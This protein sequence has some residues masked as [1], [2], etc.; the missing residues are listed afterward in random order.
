MKDTSFSNRTK[1]AVANGITNYTGTAAQ[2][3]TLLTL[4]KTGKLKVPT[5]ITI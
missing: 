3:T 1:I 2:N 4:L 5:G